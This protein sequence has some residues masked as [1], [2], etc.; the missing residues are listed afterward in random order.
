[1]KTKNIVLIT[2]SSVVIIIIIVWISYLL[3]PPQKLV[4][5]VNSKNDLLS[6]YN[7]IDTSFWYQ[8]GDY[9]VFNNQTNTKQKVTLFTNKLPSEKK[10]IGRIT[11]GVIF[12]GNLDKDCIVGFQIGKLGSKEE[13]QYVVGMNGK[14]EIVTL[15]G[16]LEPLTDELISK[17]PNIVDPKK[18]AWLSLFTLGNP[19]G[20]IIQF[21]AKNRNAVGNGTSVQNV[22]KEILMSNEKEISLVVYNPNQKGNISFTQWE[23][24]NDWTPND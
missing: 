20:G 5:I 6:E 12:S 24:Q 23:I 13:E 4:K 3:L 10:K 1:M 17:G 19:N 15:N 21:S 9:L 7:N 22:P 14:G 11:T 2:I 18:E 8:D 16:L